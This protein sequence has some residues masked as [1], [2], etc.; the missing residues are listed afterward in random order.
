MGKG[1]LADAV[2]CLNAED[3]RQLKDRPR[4]RVYNLGITTM[5]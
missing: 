5:T 4:D 2:V 3:Q 1:D